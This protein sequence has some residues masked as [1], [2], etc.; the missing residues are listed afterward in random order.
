MEGPDATYGFGAGDWKCYTS[1]MPQCHGYGGTVSRRPACFAV[2][3]ASARP[4][5][6]AVLLALIVLAGPAAEPARCVGET[7]HS[8]NYAFATQ[9]GSGIYRVDGRTVHIYRVSLARRFR[10]PDPDSW[11][12][13]LVIRTTLGF[14]SLSFEDVIGGDLPDRFQTLSIVPEL[15]F[16]APVMRD[17]WRLLPFVA[18]GGGQDFQ[19]GEFNFIFAAGVRNWFIWPWKAATHFRLGNR[20]VYSVATSGD[21][22]FSDDFGLFETTA[23][24]RKPLGFSIFGHAMDG[25]ST[26]TT[27]RCGSLRIGKSGSPSGRSTRGGCW[28][29]KFP[30]SAWATGSTRR[31]RPS[32]SS[33]ARPSRSPPGAN[34]PPPSSS[35]PASSPG[36]EGHA[37]RIRSIR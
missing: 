4:R 9:I 30:A 32:G 13:R 5:G 17:Y 1:A 12:L 36:V 6:L 37:E 23:D 27:T 15:E 7:L 31:T 3:L 25:R 10:Y 29:S 21:V 20:L 24:L 34:A 33:S 18:A 26:S 22:D 28:G 35:R 11:G 19:G 16:E 8:I 14:Y 2:R